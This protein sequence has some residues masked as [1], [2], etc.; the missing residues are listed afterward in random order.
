M[1][2]TELRLGIGVVR[3]YLI[4]E[5]RKIIKTKSK[6][7]SS[8]H[9]KAT[10]GISNSTEE[11]TGQQTVEAPVVHCGGTCSDTFTSVTFDDSSRVN[12]SWLRAVAGLFTLFTFSDTSK[13][14]IQ[15]ERCKP[16]FTF[17]CR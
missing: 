14:I 17:L 16:A 11:A 2:A 4:N 8:F 5:C 15:S 13:V 12:E 3:D 1:A 10:V 7:R 9:L 6:R